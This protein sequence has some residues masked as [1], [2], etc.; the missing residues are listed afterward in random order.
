LKKKVIV[1]HS[2]DPWGPGPTRPTAKG[3][4]ERTAE[5]Q[6]PTPPNSK[7]APKQNHA[8]PEQSSKANVPPAGAL[9]TQKPHLER[10]SAFTRALSAAKV[11]LPVVQKVL[12]LLEGNVATVAANLLAP[13]PRSVDLEPVRSAIG[14]LQADQRTLRN[15]V[16]DQKATLTAIEED[17]STIKEGL[18][19]N[20]TEIRELAESQLNLR[21]RLTRLTWMIFILLALSIGF[22]TLVCIRLAYILRL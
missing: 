16:A 20:T 15:E 5:S 18:D 9:A 2:I 10:P 21:R 14:K 11:V 13:N 12:P 7:T 8:S 17:L 6:P 3:A 22:T 4:E 1:M 19:R